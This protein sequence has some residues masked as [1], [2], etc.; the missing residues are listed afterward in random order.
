MLP[1]KYRKD[2]LSALALLGIVALN[3]PILSLFSRADRLFGIPVLFLYLFSFWLLF[4]IL[5]AQVVR[6]HSKEKH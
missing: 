5:I 2:R 1:P 4:V 6:V 3:F